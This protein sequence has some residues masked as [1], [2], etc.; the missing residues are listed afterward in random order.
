MTN[1]SHKEV[2][3]KHLKI[4]LLKMRISRKLLII[5]NIKNY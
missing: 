2:S 5:Y 4:Y 1:D 3:L